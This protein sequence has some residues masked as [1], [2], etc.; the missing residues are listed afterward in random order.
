MITLQSFEHV[1]ILI[2]TVKFLIITPS[3]LLLFHFVLFNILIISLS[4]IFARD[5]NLYYF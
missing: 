4:S 2:G 3:P 5:K 1:S